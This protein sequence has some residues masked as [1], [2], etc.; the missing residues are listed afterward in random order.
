MLEKIIEWSIR[1]KF[2]VVLMTAFLV[3]GG[4]YA[5]KNT[6]PLDAIPD[7]SDVQVIVFTEYPGQAPQVSKTKSPILSPLKCLQSRKPRQCVDFL[8]SAYHSFTSFLKMVQTFIGLVR[9]F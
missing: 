5:L 2:M 1:N 9:G 4:L 8:S 3:I 7:L 6:P